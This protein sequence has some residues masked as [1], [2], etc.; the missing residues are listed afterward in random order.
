MTVWSQGS[1][2]VTNSSNSVWGQ[3]GAATT[4]AFPGPHGQLQGR[5]RRSRAE[6]SSSSGCEA[7]SSSWL[8]VS[9]PGRDVVRVEPIQQK[10]TGMIKGMEN[11]AREER[12]KGL[13]LFSLE[14]RDSDVIAPC[15]SL[16]GY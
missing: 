3:A 8:G 10:V 5:P 6:R 11:Q 16:H 2:W 13:P 9:S 4:L 7:H 12:L 15:K 1:N 14:K